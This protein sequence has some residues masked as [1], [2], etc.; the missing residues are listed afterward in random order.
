MH[1]G[2]LYD[3]I[4][5][6]GQGHG[7][8]EV[9]KIARFKVYLLCHLQWELANDHQF[10]T[11]STFH[12]AGFFFIFVLLF[13]SPISK[14]QSEGLFENLHRSR[15]SVPHGTNFCNNSKNDNS[16]QASVYGAVIVA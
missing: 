14:D 12:C 15:P 6:Q 4:Q 9:L 16:N 7:A 13:V 1:D 2:M 8:S 5:G 3:P 11:I 10:L